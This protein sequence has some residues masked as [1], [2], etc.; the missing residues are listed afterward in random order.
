MRTP[1]LLAAPA[2]RDWRRPGLVVAAVV[3]AAVAAAMVTSEPTLTFLLLFLVVGGAVALLAP[4]WMFIPIALASVILAAQLPAGL[5]AM[6]VSRIGMALA[7]L[8]LLRAAAESK[9]IKV[10]MEISIAIAVFAGSLVFSGL[11]AFALSPGWTNSLAVLAQLQG[12]DL[13]FNLQKQGMHML[14]G[15]TVGLIAGGDARFRDSAF[16]GLAWVTLFAGLASALY[17]AWNS[18]WLP[19][20]GPLESV[21]ENARGGSESRSGFPFGTNPNNQA[22]LFAALAGFIGPTLLATRKRS[23]F[24][25]AALM[26]TAAALAI[27]SS[28]SRTGILTLVIVTVGVLAVSG[29]SLRSR[30]P[31]LAAVTAMFALVISLSFLL[32]ENRQFGETGT[33]ESRIAIWEDLADDFSE[34]P[35]IGQGFQFG[36]RATGGQ[37]AH[38]EFL[39]RFVD[40]GIVGG[41]AFVITLAM[42][43]RVGWAL[44]RED[45]DRA[46]GV[47][48]LTF[49]AALAAGMMALTS[50]TT[51]G[52]IMFISW[53]FF[54][55]V[56]AIVAVRRSARSNGEPQPDATNRL[57]P[58]GSR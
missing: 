19:N 38:N 13:L 14:A 15:V 2:P 28:Q 34:S 20:A 40:G 10:P 45:I 58:L 4:L 29:E 42:F 5:G 9:P 21:F 12:G 46:V 8:L 57:R 23:D 22:V 52:P 24:W 33:V 37:S 49:L 18:G 47:G 43:L 26:L 17:W 27:L 55:M 51:G 3:A 41:L 54:G 50:W 32:P 53:M 35:V 56:G 6:S 48:M 25:L 44:F 16:R 7:F 11:I 1:Y 31:V 39:L 30:L 36:V